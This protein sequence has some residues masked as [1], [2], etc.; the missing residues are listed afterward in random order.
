[1]GGHDNHRPRPAMNLPPESPPPD[2][3]RRDALVALFRLLAG[4][5]ILL[6]ML[7]FVRA[8]FSP[9]RLPAQKA[10]PPVDAPAPST[11]RPGKY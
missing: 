8:C 9:P 7:S 2:T 4:I 1:M 5:G 3:Q 10:P 11:D 6:L